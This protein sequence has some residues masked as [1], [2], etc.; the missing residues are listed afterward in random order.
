MSGKLYATARAESIA[1]NHFDVIHPGAVALPVDVCYFS[2]A[3]L[4]TREERDSDPGGGSNFADRAGVEAVET[5]F[6]VGRLITHAATLDEFRA[7]VYGG[8][9]S[10]AFPDTVGNEPDSWPLS[11]DID[12]DTGTISQMRLIAGDNAIGSFDEVRVGETWRDVTSLPE[13]TAVSL[14]ALVVLTCVTRGRR[15]R[16][17]ERK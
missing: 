7:A 13:P 4:S 11:M 1:G 8:T 6:M 14:A 2:P 16:E 15:G 10:D 9:A 3:V 17:A 5:Y 12:N